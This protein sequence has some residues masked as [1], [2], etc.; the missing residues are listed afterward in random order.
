MTVTPGRPKLRTMPKIISASALLSEAVGSSRM[1]RFGLAQKRRRDRY[2]FALRHAQITRQSG[3][4]KA[5]ADAMQQTLRRCPHLAEVE[6]TVADDLA[7]KE[8]IAGRVELADERLVLVNDDNS[9]RFRRGR[10]C[11]S[12]PA[13]RQSASSPRLG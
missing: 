11:I 10:I 7:A 8:D 13:A 1:R 9:G 6:Q 3:R 2:E 12:G 5:R 4:R